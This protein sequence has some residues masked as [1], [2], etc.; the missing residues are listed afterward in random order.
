MKLLIKSDYYN[1]YYDNQYKLEYNKKIHYFTSF[2]SLLKQINKYL[3]KDNRDLI[4]ITEYLDLIKLSETL[5]NE[6]NNDI[7][8]LLDLSKQTHSGK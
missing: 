6:F 2:L 5:Y 4:N 3:K 7:D 8:E 1:V